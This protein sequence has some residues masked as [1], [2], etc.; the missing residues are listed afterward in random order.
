MKFPLIWSASIAALLCSAAHADEPVRKL[1]FKQA[2]D[3]A[4]AQNVDADVA[5]VAVE[6]ARERE[7]GL[8]A[9]RMPDIRVD[10]FGN[11]YTKPY[12]LDFGGQL[13][14]LHKQF[15]SISSLTVS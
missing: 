7:R 5:K 12:E 10:S 15:T 2:I 13:F 11:L 14:T 1:S 6:S 3:L 4:L 9:K 8:K